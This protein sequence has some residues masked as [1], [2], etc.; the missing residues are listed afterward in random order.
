PRRRRPEQVVRDARQDHELRHQDEHR[1]G[2][3]LVRGHRGVRRGLE[4]P[5]QHRHAADQVQAERAGDRQRD[6]HGR[7][8]E[9]H[10]EQGAEDDRAGHSPAP[11]GIDWSRGGGTSP[12]ASPAIVE[13]TW[14]MQRWAQRRVMRA[15]PIAAGAS[16]SQ[17]GQ[18]MV[19]AVTS[20][21][22]YAVQAR[23]PSFQ[24]MS[25]ITTVPAASPIASPAKRTR[26]GRNGWKKSIAM[27]PC[28]CSVPGSAQKNTAPT[29]YMPMRS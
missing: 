27:W 10:R 1:D 14:P 23:A 2:D 12:L 20:P 13:I 22:T 28:T 26:G 15:L 8:H 6:R 21:F 29:R 16:D 4:D 24:A 17:I 25:A 18:G 19:V 9:E 3:Q 11:P 5:E 7:A